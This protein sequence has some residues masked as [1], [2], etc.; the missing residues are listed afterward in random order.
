MKVKWQDKVSTRELL[1]RASMESLN[2]NVRRRHI[3]RQEP[4]NDCIR[5]L[6]WALEGK[7]KLGKPITTWRHT[8]EKELR[9]RAW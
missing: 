5:A 1:E 3:L 8:V 4:D 9:S 2:D 7:R 6:T